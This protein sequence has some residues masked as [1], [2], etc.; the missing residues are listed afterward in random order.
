MLLDHQRRSSPLRSRS[1]IL[2]AAMKKTLVAACSLVALCASV[3]SAAPGIDLAWTNCGL[4]GTASQTWVCDS[5]S[6]VPFVL[7]ASFIPPSGINQFVGI[8]SQ[9]DFTST[10]PVL[11]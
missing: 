2:E 11:P 7:I 10:T 1:C 5:N 8:T 3:A 6:G 9:V 4:A